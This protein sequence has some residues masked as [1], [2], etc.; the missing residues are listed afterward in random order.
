MVTNSACNMVFVGIAQHNNSRKGKG[1]G[2][3]ISGKH[4]K[5]VYGTEFALN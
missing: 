4:T 5:S 2:D 3:N 1:Y